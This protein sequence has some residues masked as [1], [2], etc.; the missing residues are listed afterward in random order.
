MGS[1]HDDLSK[2]ARDDTERDHHIAEARRLWSSI[3]RQDMI[4]QYLPPLP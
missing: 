4:E 1:V 2:V 3:K